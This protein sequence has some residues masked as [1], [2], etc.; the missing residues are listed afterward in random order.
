M[1]IGRPIATSDPKASSRMTTPR[2]RPIGLADAGRRLLEGE[3]QVAAHLDPQR[4]PAL[5][6]VVRGALEVASGRPGRSSSIDRVLQPDAARPARRPRSPRPRRPRRRPAASAPAGSLVPSTCG[7]ARRP[8]G[9]WRAPRRAAGESRNVAAWSSGVSDD[10]GRE[11]GRDGAARRPAAR[12]PAGS[13]APAPGR[14]PRAGARRPPTA[15][16]TSDGEHDPG[17]DHGP[18]ATGRPAAQTVQDA[19]TSRLLHGSGLRRRVL[20]GTSASREPTAAASAGSPGPAPAF[21]PG[22]VSYFR[23][24]RGRARIPTLGS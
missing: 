8:P 12:S 2:R 20:P 6:T 4:R 1:P 16:T 15:D 17:P 21:R 9:R 11:T 18:G 14:S 24:S 7:S 19:A 13:R 5:R 3:E 22:G 23:P 10:L